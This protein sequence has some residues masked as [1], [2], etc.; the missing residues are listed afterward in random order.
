MPETRMLALG[1]S[2]LTEGFALIGFETVP[3]ATAEDLEAVLA[4][5]VRGN[6]RAMV[7]VERT[8]ARGNGRW[9]NQVRN[10]GGRIVL[11]EVPELNA[12]SNYHPLVEDLVESILGPQALEDKSWE[13]KT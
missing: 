5:L 12:P 10:E 6:Q 1:S 2:A 4:E 8:L 13:E 9:L 7:I 3:D 11:A